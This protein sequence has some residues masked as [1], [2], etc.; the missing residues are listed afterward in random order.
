MFTCFRCFLLDGA[1]HVDRVIITPHVFLA[2]YNNI[3]HL[4]LCLSAAEDHDV[5]EYLGRLFHLHLRV[6]SSSS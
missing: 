1:E 2:L 4:Q 3:V 6:I 5:L